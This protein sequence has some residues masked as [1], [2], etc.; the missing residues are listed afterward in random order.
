MTTIAHSVYASVAQRYWREDWTPERNREVYAADASAEGLGANMRIE[1]E[2]EAALRTE[3]ELVSA[4]NDLKVQLDHQCL[5]AA[6]SPL[7]GQPSTLENIALH[8]ART[9]DLS[10]WRKLTLWE[11]DH[12]GCEVEAQAQIE[13]KMIFKQRNL[14]LEVKGSM[15]RDSGIAVPRARVRLAVEDLLVKF[16]SIHD[17]DPRVWGDKL[18]SALRTGLPGL[19]SVRVDLGRHE[20]LVVQSP[21]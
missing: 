7:V 2:G 10:A 9:I 4:L 18:F 8:L 19:V 20:G 5:F 3:S 1:L 6:E 16:S 12:L 11:S 13:V 14:T 21:N 15:E 17:S